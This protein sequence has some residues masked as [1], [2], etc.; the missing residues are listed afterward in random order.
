[1]DTHALVGSPDANEDVYSA[2]QHM[3]TI[4]G[5]GREL[6]D[7]S[8][9]TDA[10]ARVCE[11]LIGGL[12]VCRSCIAMFDGAGRV[13]KSTLRRSPER[14]LNSE[15]SVDSRLME[16]L[17]LRCYEKNGVV[18][19]SPVVTGSDDFAFAVP[20][21]KDDEII[22]AVCVSRLAKQQALDSDVLDT[23]K[24]ITLQLGSALDRLNLTRALENQAFHDPLTRLANR[25]KFEM[26]LNETLESG[27]PGSLLFIDLDGFKNINDT[28]G[29]GVGD[30]LLCHVAKRLSNQ[31][32]KCDSLARIGGDEFTVILRESN[33]V[34]AATVCANRLLR[35]L[36]RTFEIQNAQ[37]KVGASIGVSRYPQDGAT[38]DK[39]L[40]SA[41][42][43][44]YE[45][46]NSGKGRVLMYNQGTVDA[47]LEVTQLHEEL[48][49]ALKEDQFELN[50]QPQVSC[51]LNKVVGVEALLRWNHPERGCLP[52]GEF[53]PLA[54]ETGLIVEIGDW[55]L[56]QALMQMSLWQA[57][58]EL[59]NLRV[60]INVAALQLQ[61]DAYVNHVLQ[62]I[63]F[64]NVPAHLV[65]L[66]LTESV[67]MDDIREVAKRIKALQNA[68]LRIA[69][70]DFGTGYSSLSYLQDLPLDVL[71]ID[72]A[73]VSRLE[74]EEPDKSLVNTIAL[75]AVGLELETVAEGIETLKQRDAITAMGCDLI[76]GH[77]YSKAV[78]PEKILEYIKSTGKG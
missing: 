5:I 61:N 29:H 38:V 65:E 50:Y 32:K 11:H 39:L 44:M 53:I 48:H 13:F 77:Y 12:K 46:K 76:Q 20:L 16:E 63:A 69:I 64:Y 19:E 30:Q 47:R 70:D 28:L 52:P 73:F 58:P 60:G 68:G 14:A 54:E 15:H 33:D 17:A 27:N 57:E 37:V 67:V 26:E 71:K 31:L 72:R 23:L 8:S 34:A 6:N 1:V 36:S 41:D 10:C 43:A 56:D 24:I 7:V 59:Q 45:A 2:L 66:E 22:G 78:K 25:A 55:V 9:R 18:I 42:M 62:K 51:S 74:N 4:A 49:Q 35:A 75:L 21:L 40:R 3:N